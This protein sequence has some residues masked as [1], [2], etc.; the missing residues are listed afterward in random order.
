MKYSTVGVSGQTLVG[1]GFIV[2]IHLQ[3]CL[4]LLIIV[5]GRP[6]IS[7]NSKAG[8]YLDQH[9]CGRLDPYWSKALDPH[10]SILSLDLL[11]TTTK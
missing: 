5:I 7:R 8:F 10:Q 2:S 1:H 9:N 3:D 6:P 11:F 4:K